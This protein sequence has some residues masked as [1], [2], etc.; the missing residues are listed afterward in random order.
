MNRIWNFIIRCLRFAKRK[1]KG[2]KRRINKLLGKPEEIFLNLGQVCDE[3][4][5]DKKEEIQFEEEIDVIVPIYNGYDYLVRLFPTLNR[6]N[7]KCHIYLVDDC[8]TDYRVLELEKE[9]E[10]QNSNVTVIVNDQNY[11]FVMSVNRALLNS[12]NHVALV[13]TD[14]ELPQL[15]L[16]RLMAPIILD[17]RVASSTPYT[18]SATIFSF[19]N[20]CYN[21]EIYRGMSVEQIDE[22]FSCIKPRY[23]KAPTGVGFCMVMNK[24]AIAEIG[25]LDY[26][27]FSKGFGEE[28]D[29][30]QR[31]IKR[32]YY[33]VQVENLFVYHKHGGSFNSEEKEALI[34]NNMSIINKRYPT[35]ESD[36]TEFILKDPNVAIREVVQMILDM[37]CEGSI[38]NLYFDHSLGGG[39]TAYLD[40]KVKEELK[41]GNACSVIRFRYWDCKFLFEF[42]CGEIHRTFDFDSLDA[43]MK[44]EKWLHF[45]RIYVNELVTFHNLKYTLDVIK[46]LALNQRAKL[47]F[48]FHDYFAVCPTINLVG[49]DNCY[50]EFPK[51]EKCRDCFT[52]KKLHNVFQCEDVNE[53]R[54]IWKPF[55]ESC[56]EVRTFSKDTL[57]RIRGVFGDTLKYTLVPHK[58]DYLFPLKKKYKITKEINIGVLGILSQNKGAEVVR[59]MLEVLERENKRDVRIKLIGETEDDSFQ[60]YQ[61]FSKTGR[62]TQGE[63]PRLIFENDIDVIL[64]PSIWPETFSYTTEEAI[65][66]EMPV[67]CFDLGAPADRV[68]SYKKGIVIPKMNPSCALETIEGFVRNNL[69]PTRNTLHGKEIVYITEYVSF[70]SRYRL[71]HLYEEM[72]REGYPGQLWSVDSFPKKI[73]WNRI[74]QI[75]IYRCK[76]V[77]PLKSFLEEAER[78]KIPIAYS[79]DDLIF[80]YE[81]IKDFDFFDTRVYHNLKKY[82]EEVRNAIDN[83]QAIISSTDTLGDCLLTE[84]PNK[85]VVVDRNVASMEM[86]VLSNKARLQK[87]IHDS[88]VVLG[89]FS[90]SGTHNGDFELIS[91]V[92][93]NILKKNSNVSLL[94]VGVLELNKK[95]DCFQDRIKRV[96]FVDWRQLP[97][98]LASIDI[99]LMPLEDTK[100]HYCK[101]ENKW[102]E[103]AMVEVPTIGSYN[104]EIASHTKD[105]EDIVL[106]RNQEQW[107]NVLQT[108][109]DN[110]VERRRVAQNAFKRVID[111]KNTGYGHEA[112]IRCLTGEE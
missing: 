109:I 30:C 97:E 2:L 15:W 21:N 108:L 56:D 80:D 93:F 65:Q 94:I 66:M 31:A 3:L 35:Y 67:A 4:L 107:L 10:D 48:L 41:D 8:S 51:A 55:L 86:W 33:N 39:A 91:D 73:D 11:G 84:F 90:G 58:V 37:K 83:S 42:F 44:V 89:Y 100:F 95:F 38:S 18:N 53:W 112:V 103:A 29:W 85:K 59:Q 105:G 62:Y 34:R 24:N 20:F 102:M 50:C 1:Y 25:G 74:G 96:G 5:T 88:E 36:V 69:L 12:K 78:K 99:N 82:T 71:E 6:T 13:N 40:T 60:R 16:E 79:I 43:F 72:L 23:V 76:K 64:I 106:C 46:K 57:E 19:P 26:E 7:I 110:S 98:F 77:E 49:E 92:L 17:N 81:Q 32:G 63:L 61:Y 28:N 75:V 104:P 111:E 47:I 54:Q 68:A 70:S 87:K 101:S 22:V 52:G 14:T 9:F 45:D 27:A